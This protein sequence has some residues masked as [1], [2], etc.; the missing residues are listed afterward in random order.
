MQKKRKE[1]RRETQKRKEDGW[2][3][4]GIKLRKTP[5]FRLK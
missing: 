1:K 2:E 3:T 4:K 5:E